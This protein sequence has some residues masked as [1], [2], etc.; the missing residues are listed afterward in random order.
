M[1]SSG[2][3]KQSTNTIIGYGPF[4]AS[5]DGE[6]AQT[7]L[8]I[9]QA[10]IIIRKTGGNTWAQKAA[11][12]GA[13]A[14]ASGMYAVNVGTGDS[15][16][17][18]VLD[19]FSHV[20]P[21]LYVKQSYTVLPGLVYDSIIGGSDFLQVDSHQASGTNILTLLDNA[22][23]SRLAAT[24]TEV[25]RIDVTVSS[26]VPATAASL[27]NLD[28]TTSSRLAATAAVLNMI[29]VSGSSRVAATA[30]TWGNLDATVSSVYTKASGAATELGVGNIDVK[31]SSRAAATA[32]TLANLDVLVSSRLAGT[33]ASLANLDVT[34]S[35]RLA[36][37]ATAF[38]NL[39]VLV[40]SR[41]AGTAQVSA[42]YATATQVTD[43]TGYALTTAFDPATQYVSAIHATAT[44]VSD[45]TGY[46]LTAVY[47]LAKTA[48]QASAVESVLQKT[49][50]TTSS[51]LA[52]TA[53]EV[54][55]IDAAISTRA[56]SADMSN[57][58]ASAVDI[59]DFSRG[60]KKIDVTGDGFT[61]YKSDG[62]TIL[63]SYSMSGANPASVVPAY[64]K[65]TRN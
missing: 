10:D 34:T 41:M 23:S 53:T 64:I 6:T 35:S 13:T 51:R 36:A 26:R 46:A 50:V 32:A 45:K 60:N 22:I 29:D 39:D 30:A 49:D 15:D 28:V 47:D 37:T 21:A 14:V 54:G 43:K 42:V 62:T 17:V 24:A 3:L 4:V 38:A 18:G 48:A 5:A 56:S 12:G 27:T 9:N 58:S 1:G 19:L 11:T 55:R 61:A 65:S 57:V 31:V 20:S 52:A 40:S 25:G 16:T 33:A 63:W 7:A 44:Q 8:T 59:W 2:F